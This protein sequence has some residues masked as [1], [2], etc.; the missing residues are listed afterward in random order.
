MLL[1]TRACEDLERER[2]E[3]EEEKV[4]YL[5]EKLPPLQLSG[6][7]L[8]ELQVR[9]LKHRGKKRKKKS[10]FYSRKCMS[11]FDQYIKTFF[12]PSESMQT[13]SCKNWCCGWGEIW[14]WI[15]SEQTQQRCKSLSTLLHLAHYSSYHAQFSQYF[16]KNSCLL[17]LL[18]P[19]IKTWEKTR[20]KFFWTFLTNTNHWTFSSNPDSTAH[21]YSS[22]K[23]YQII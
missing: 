5:G 21:P 6:L 1:L 9:V 16:K 17:W 8:D 2:Q 10:F 3:R 23:H 14:L 12:P 7:P 18:W 22:K 4:R 19:E 11:M 15:Q 13:A 20:W